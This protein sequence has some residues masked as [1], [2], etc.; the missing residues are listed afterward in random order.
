VAVKQDF[1]RMGHFVLGVVHRFSSG[2][3]NSWGVS[4]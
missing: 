4:L 2:K 1:M 3:I